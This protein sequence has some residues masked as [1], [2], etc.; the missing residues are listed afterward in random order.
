MN[1]TISCQSF[2]SGIVH[3]FSLGS[4][5]NTPLTEFYLYSKWEKKLNIVCV[6]NVRYPLLMLMYKMD[7]D[8]LSLLSIFGWSGNAV[9]DYKTHVEVWSSLFPFSICFWSCMF[10]WVPV[11]MWRVPSHTTSNSQTLTDSPRIQFNSDIV[12]YHRLRAQSCKTAQHTSTPQMPVASPDCLLCFW[13]L[14]YINSRFLWP[15]P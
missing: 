5:Q 15:C 14:G 8:I 12:R 7:I 4:L 3:S 1:A 11:C 10:L 9:L 2:E 13:P 6:E